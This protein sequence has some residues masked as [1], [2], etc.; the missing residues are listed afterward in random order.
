M[1]KR[2]VRL[3]LV[4]AG[5]IVLYTVDL[6]RAPIYL[7][8]AE[9]LF[10]L[11]AQS[12]ATTLHDTNGRLLPLYFQMPQIGANVW[13]HPMI[14]YAMV[15]FLAVLPLSEFAIRLPSVFVGLVDI[16]LV[17]FIAARLFR[18]E[19]WALLAAALLVLTPSH[20]IHSRVA[21]DYLYPV[22]FVLGW[23][24]GLQLFLA[25]RDRRLLFVATSCLGVGF[26]SYIASVGMMPLYLLMTL[27][28]V[29]LEGD[30]SFR[31]SAVA[32]A[33]F[34]WPLVLLIWI[35]FHPAF[36]AQT[37]ARYQVGQSAPPGHAA[38]APLSVVL[39][40]LRNVARFSPV[41]GRISLYWYFFDPSYLFVTGGYANAV[42]SVR[43]V[44]VFP[45]PFAVLLPV[46]LV[47]LL[48][49]PGAIVDRLVVAGFATAPL[50]AC[51]VVPEP[52]AIDRELAL[53]PFGVLAAVA[54]ARFLQGTRRRVW[55]AAAVVLLAAVPAHFAFFLY[56]YYRDYPPHAAFWFNWNRRGAMETLLALD[57]RQRA[58]AIYI[59][60]HHVTYIDAYWRLY[61]IKHK[62]EELLRRT[63]YFDS[64][65]FDVSAVPPGALLLTGIDDTSLNPAIE[66]GRLRRVT[67]IAE[68]GNPPSFFILEAAG[69]RAGSAASVPAS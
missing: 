47:A 25:R 26:Y 28:V 37:A 55:R 50:V 32:I 24:L 13:F 57:D 23:L 8:E 17:Y 46:G 43:H 63:I 16:T 66:T 49:V 10:A 38:G 61:L 36:V 59:S 53:L 44:G 3:A 27:A 35:V 68:P 2:Y 58:P 33:G 18:S 56:D 7:H 14:V 39:E 29:W 22:P 19:R 41:T 30:T 62:R 20:F 51:L 15:P 9:V 64:D 1:T 67:A 34:T 12:I 40:D 21:M 5:A 60:T 45:A 6:G 65:G 11:H 54:G 69:A 4:L 48:A 31:S 42:N 52:Y